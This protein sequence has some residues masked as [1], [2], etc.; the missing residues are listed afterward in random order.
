ML[1]WDYL[2]NVF[3]RFF[4]FKH[5][6]L[7]KCKY[8]FYLL[9]STLSIA[10][11]NVEFLV[12][13]SKAITLG[14]LCA[15]LAR[16]VPYACLV[17]TL[18]PFEYCG[19]EEREILEIFTAGTSSFRGFC[20]MICVGPEF[21][22]RAWTA[23][24]DSSALAPSGLPCQF[25]SSSIPGNPLPFSVLANMADGLSLDRDASWKAW[26]FKYFF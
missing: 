14:L 13:P 12:S 8:C 4:F 16:A 5:L 9:G 10:L 1:I 25:S 18:S 24:K 6:K 15:S 20:G 21:L 2:E 23:A 22:I 3:E 11:E 26:K 19:G 7:L 17:A